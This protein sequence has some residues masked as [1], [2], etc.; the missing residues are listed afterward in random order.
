VVDKTASSGFYSP[1]CI[2][3]ACAGATV[4]VLAFCRGCCKMQ[5]APAHA[6]LGKHSLSLS[7][8]QSNDPPLLPPSPSTPGL[9]APRPPTPPTSS[10]IEPMSHHIFGDPI[11]RR[12]QPPWPPPPHPTDLLHSRDCILHWSH[13]PPPQ[14]SPSPIA[15]STPGCLLRRRPPRRR[16]RRRRSGRPR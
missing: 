16:T 4:A 2:F 11:L 14:S 3:I 10:T 1:H 15:S 6:I 5:Q 13:P 7:F 9:L 8:A 12:A